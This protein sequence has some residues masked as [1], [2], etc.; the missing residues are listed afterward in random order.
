MKC[1]HI[2]ED[3]IYLI[4]NRATASNPLF[5]SKRD[6]LEF[7]DKVEQYLAP[8]CKV[9]AHALH[10][11]Q[12]QLLIKTKSRNHFSRFFK[13]KHKG[14]TD[15]KLFIP[16]STHIFSQQMSN[17]QVSVAK[18]F[19]FKNARKGA[20]FASRFERRMMKSEQDLQLWIGRL[21]NG[22]QYFDT[23]KKWSNQMYG[24]SGKILSCMNSDEGFRQRVRAGNVAQVG[25]LGIMK[26]NLGDCF[27]GTLIPDLLTP[28]LRKMM[29]EHRIKYPCG[30]NYN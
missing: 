8:I 3:R 9:L 27:L 12:F 23:A 16:L 30:P 20:L 21:N 11:D 1:R 6:Q 15:E 26:S 29:I 18:R 10:D 5:L 2:L 25:V 14:K 24:K 17:L 22:I 19:N 28:F 7:L 4:S 13:S